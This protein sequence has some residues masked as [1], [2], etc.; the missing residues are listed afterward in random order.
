MLS[1]ILCGC[2]LL[3]QKRKKTKRAGNFSISSVLLRRRFNSR[4]SSDS[5]AFTQI[6]VNFVCC[7]EAKLFIFL[8]KSF[9]L[10]VSGACGEERRRFYNKYEARRGEKQKTFVCPHMYE[11]IIERI[12]TWAIGEEEQ[13]NSFWDLKTKTK[14]GD[15]EEKQKRTHH[16]RLRQDNKCISLSRSSVVRAP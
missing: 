2:K 15:E 7:A 10:P 11:N 12:S 3:C 5:F 14:E 1:D 13:K 16:N 8:Q 9:F 4:N 6:Y